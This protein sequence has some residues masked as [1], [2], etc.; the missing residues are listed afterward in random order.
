MTTKMIVLILLAFMLFSCNSTEL[1]TE[2]IITIDPRT[3]TESKIL[4]SEIADDISYIPL[5]NQ[6]PF[7]LTYNF[8]IING[9]LYASI[10]DIGVVRFTKDGNLDVKYGNIG[11][12]PNEY[13]Y[14][15]SFA[16]NPDNGTVYVMDQK[17]SNVQVYSKNGVYARAIKLPKD[18]DGFM[19]SDIEFFNSS[20]VFAQYFNMG[21]GDH[22]LIVLDTL[23]N[24]ISEKKN[25]YLEF[26]GRIGGRG[27][28]F[29]TGKNLGY[30]DEFKDTIFL[31]TSDFKYKP[32]GLI[33]KGDF[34]LPITDEPYKNVEN[35]LKNMPKYFDP[36]N[37]ID[38]GSFFVLEYFFDNN[39]YLALIDKNTGS[40]KTIQLKDKEDGIPNNID[41]GL[42]FLPEVCCEIEGKVFLA[43][44]IQPFIL[45]TYTSSDKFK[46]STP[47][48]PEKKKQLEQLANSLDENDNPVLML[49]NLK[50]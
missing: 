44:L 23:G 18:E 41:S 50:E 2:E 21:R 45:K 11:R 1:K 38:S 15:M 29:K 16:I 13:L 5:D 10:K 47:K 49:V 27:G 25:S 42:P 30:W 9:F 6:F 31:I 40:A 34:R 46:N 32:M 35:L 17:M 26:K 14:C 3:Y 33:A 12:G 20:L 37:I 19:L 8:K 7:G 24:K 28:L 22:D 48:Y 36:Y 39:L 4:L 43:S